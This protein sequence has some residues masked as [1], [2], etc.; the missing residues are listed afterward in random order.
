MESTIFSAGC[1]EKWGVF[2]IVRLPAG[3]RLTAV[4]VWDHPIAAL[5]R[6]GCP[7]WLAVLMAS[8]LLNPQLIV[9]S[10]AWGRSAY[11]AIIS[12]FLAA[13]PR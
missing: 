10:A 4:H 13:A 12:C 3:H 9:Y 2:G 7:Y 11:G 1:R 5:S 6:R 8:I